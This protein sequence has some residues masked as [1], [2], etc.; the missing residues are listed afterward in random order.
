MACKLQS[1]FFGI[2]KKRIVAVCYNR[3]GLNVPIGKE[4]KTVFAHTTAVS[5]PNERPCALEGAVLIGYILPIG[6]LLLSINGYDLSRL[7][8]ALPADFG[9]CAI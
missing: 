9:S 6:V 4:N 1:G 3:I 2:A 7:P 5:F 8:F